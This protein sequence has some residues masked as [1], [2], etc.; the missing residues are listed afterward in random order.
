[1]TGP[2]AWSTASSAVMTSRSGGSARV[3]RCTLAQYSSFQVSRSR[4]NA[5][6][7]SVGGRTTEN[8]PSG[9][10]RA[11]TSPAFLSR[12][13]PVSLSLPYNVTFFNW[14]DWARDLNP[15]Y[16]MALGPSDSHNRMTARTMS[17]RATHPPV[18][19][20]PLRRTG[21]GAGGS[22]FSGGVIRT[23][24]RFG[25]AGLGHLIRNPRR[26]HVNQCESHRPRP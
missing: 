8:L 6:T 19:I 24:E 3:S 5:R 1:M 21:A 14:P 22:G 26:S 16:E 18:V 11:R 17:P 7:F 9:M 23:L 10:P 25:A 4:A 12:T 15:E 13:S 2:V 20:G